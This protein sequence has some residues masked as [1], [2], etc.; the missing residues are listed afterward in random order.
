[1]SNRLNHQPGTLVKIR[2]R[3][4]VVLP[5]DDA[6][7]LLIKPLGGSDEEATGI[8]LPLAEAADKPQSAEFPNPDANDL[9]DF[10]RACAR[11]CAL[12]AWPC[13][14]GSQESSRSGPSDDERTVQ[15]K[16]WVPDV[17]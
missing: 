12:R 6:D 5:S 10:A 1:M 4:W 9:G 2:D 3:D 17:P 8:F 15:L 13:E 11:C 7:L 16:K 14:K